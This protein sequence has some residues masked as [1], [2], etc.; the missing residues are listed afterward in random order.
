VAVRPWVVHS[1]PILF[2]IHTIFNFIFPLFS[3]I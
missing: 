1:W 3:I 2:S